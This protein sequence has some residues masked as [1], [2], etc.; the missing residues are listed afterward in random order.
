[1]SSQRARL[2]RHRSSRRFRY[3]KRQRTTRHA[4]QTQASRRTT[5]QRHH[6]TRNEQEILTLS[7]QICRRRLQPGQQFT[8]T[9]SLQA[10]LQRWLTCYR[11]EVFVAVFFDRDDRLLSVD[12]I[13]IGSD[14]EARFQLRDVAAL[15]LASQ[16]HTALF[17]HN[18]PSGDNTP[19]LADQHAT[20]RLAQLLIP[21]DIHLHDHW[22]VSKNG[23]L[24]MLDDGYWS[25]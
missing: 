4:R 1:M 8:D 6:R 16:A 21:L 2:V 9:P 24:S 12:I 7:M 23:V 25:T 3:P 20:Q 14:C 15:A 10:C 19:S 5:P 17:V 18:H 22:I 13:S 11:Q